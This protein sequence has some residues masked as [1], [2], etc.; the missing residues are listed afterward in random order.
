ML[1]GL[2]KERGWSAEL[3]PAT[4]NFDEKSL[5]ARWSHKH[6]AHL[7]GLGRFGHHHLLIT[8][9]GCAGRLGSLVTDAP[10]GDNPVMEAEHACLHKAGE[11]CLLCV[12]NCPVAA[13]TEQG[14]DR[15]RCYNRLVFN[16][17]KAGVLKGAARKHTR[18]RQVR[19]GFALHF[20]QSTFIAGPASPADRIRRWRIRSLIGVGALFLESF[21]CRRLAVADRHGLSV[22]LCGRSCLL[23]RVL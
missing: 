9:N 15:R 20:Y 22:S 2:L 13:L 7:C 11:E 12:K 17:E 3:T 14:F 19:H 10:L 8:P 5:M 1:A 18:L 21:A 6:L 23:L 4:A 16:I